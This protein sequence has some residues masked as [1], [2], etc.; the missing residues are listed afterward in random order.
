VLL[1][2]VAEDVARRLVGTAAG[3]PVWVN[4][5]AGRTYRLTGP[6][7]TRFLK[8]S[9]PGAPPGHDV[10]VEAERLRWAGARVPVPEVL[11]TGSDDGV[12]WL[13]TAGLP[14]TPASDPR[15]R[16]DPTWTAHELGRAARSFHDGLA[17]ALP[18]CPW[19]WRIP[20]RLAAAADADADRADAGGADA[21][22]A[23]SL[24][25]HA[26]PEEDLVV[27]HGDLCLPNL[28]LGT[29]GLLTGFVDLGR[30]GVADR[31]ADLGALVWSL[32]YNGLEAV[33]EEFLAAYGRG[34]DRAAVEWYRAF[35]PLA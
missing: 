24:A 8:L 16:A 25:T 10:L 3:D 17:A 28:L 14:G 19:S 33:A 18:D 20:D 31:A 5:L 32:G 23:R 26:P 2:A 22:R 29:D 1:D 34:V 35:Y 11:A 15:W 7:G 9:P 21:D 13:L 4:P 6:A 12:H 27:G 30:L